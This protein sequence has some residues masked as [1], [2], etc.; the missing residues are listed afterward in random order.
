MSKRKREET[1]ENH[2]PTKRRKVDFFD[3]GELLKDFENKL[4]ESCRVNKKR[5][6]DEHEKRM[7]EIEKDIEKIVV[8]TEAQ[9]RKERD[10]R[11]VGS[12][13]SIV[14]NALQGLLEAGEYSVGVLNFGSTCYEDVNRDAQLLNQQIE[15]YKNLQGFYFC[16][17][18]YKDFYC[19]CG[20]CFETELTFCVR[21]T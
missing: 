20:K 6:K 2:P 19:C 14:K 8:K 18:E 12:F 3:D 5:R 16:A 9:I 4:A 1:E 11:V 7:Q 10:K 17:Q 21:K 15:K 13:D